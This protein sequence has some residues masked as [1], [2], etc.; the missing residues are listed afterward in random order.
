MSEESLKVIKFSGKKN[1]YVYWAEKFEARARLKGY[2]GVLDG[3]IT[4]ENDS[5]TLDPNT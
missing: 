4:I 1:D 5:V 2:A 3:S